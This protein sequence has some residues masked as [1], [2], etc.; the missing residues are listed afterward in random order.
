MFKYANSKL[1]FNLLMRLENTEAKLSEVWHL[2]SFGAHLDRQWQETELT[3]PLSLIFYGR[4][5]S[6]AADSSARK[7]IGTLLWLI[8]V[9]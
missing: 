8:K 9:V 4:V 3:P 6:P 2:I 1:K 7:L 5:C